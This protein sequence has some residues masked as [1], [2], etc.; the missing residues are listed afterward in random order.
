MSTIPYEVAYL[1]NNNFPYNPNSIDWGYTL[2]KASFNTVG[3]RVTQVLSTKI[4]T[5]TWQG[6]AGSRENLLNLYSNFKQIQNY[7]IDTEN[8][9][10][11][12]VP[13]RNW[14]IK[15]WARSM[16]VGWDY[17]SVTY[18]YRMQFEVD[19]DFGQISTSLTSQE[20]LKLAEGIGWSPKYSGIGKGDG[21]SNTDPLQEL[22]KYVG[23]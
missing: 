22:H 23:I 4:D 18:P 21:S 10:D 20:V 2:N 16:E 5:L 6:D 19:E 9:V 17:Q 14:S 13:S 8:S 15:V 1:N 3:G 12:V 7:Q 11:L